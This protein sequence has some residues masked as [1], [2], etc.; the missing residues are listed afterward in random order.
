MTADIE[1]YDLSYLDTADP[2]ILVFFIMATYG[3]GEPTDNAVEFWD[4]LTEESPLFSESQ[5]ADALQKL[6][7]AAFGLGN[8]TYEHYNEVIRRVDSCLSSLGAQRIGEVGEGDDDNSLEEDFLAWQET[9]WPAFC[10]ALGVDES[11]ANKGPRQPI[12]NVKEL[13]PDNNRD[14][15]LGEIGEWIKE[16]ESTVYDAKRPYYATL[17]SKELFE[18]SDRH[19]LHLEIDISGT[20]LSYQTGDHVAIWPTNNEEQVDLLARVLGLKDKLDTVVSVEALDPAAPK[21]HP[22]PVPTTYRAALRHYLDLGSV[23]SRQSLMSFV[24]FAPTETSQQML[25]ALATDK[26]AYR[27]RVG[28][29]NLSLG[30]VLTMVMESDASEGAFGSIPFDLIIESISRL[31][32]RYYSI[33]SSSRENPQSIAVTLV[34]LEYQPDTTPRTVYGVNTNY[35][36]RMHEKMHQMPA[37]GPRYALEGPRERLWDGKTA[38]VPVHVRR[39]TFKLPQDPSIPIIMVGPGT[40]VAPFR[41]FVRER[42]LQKKNGPVGPTVLFFGCRNSKE[43]FLYKDEW[44]GLFDTLG[45]DSRLITAFSRETDRKVYVQHRLMEHAVEM[46]GLLE[47]GAYIYVCGDAKNMARDVNQTFI[48]FAQQL[49]GM[50]EPKAQ[51][52]IKKLRNTSRYQEDVWS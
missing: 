24:E 41:G 20:N 23:A 3:E 22:F 29:V 19:C 51:D 33:S 47:K 9:M 11:G 21:K 37:S 52:Y 8:K 2:D 1:Q 10:Q 31:Q 36:L 38:R 13:E 48:R 45:D 50:S 34:S 4:F 12:Y 42:V 32:P 5:E 6:R 16:N 43:D 44:P 17:T 25:K 49:G 27:A 40:G 30:E 7:Y 15:Y 46:W 35:I 39:S 18:D 14:V 26:T 28:D